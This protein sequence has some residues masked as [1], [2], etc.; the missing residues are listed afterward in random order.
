MQKESDSEV[1]HPVVLVLVYAEEMN[2]RRSVCMRHPMSVAAQLMHCGRSEDVHALQSKSGVKTMFS[3][4]YITH[5]AHLYLSISSCASG[6][7]PLYAAAMQHRHDEHG[8]L[9]EGQVPPPPLRPANLFLSLSVLR[10]YGVLASLSI[11]INILPRK[12]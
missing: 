11:S 8:R 4:K 9:A 10:I 7:L 12:R 5:Y 3:I 2:R 6:F 1:A